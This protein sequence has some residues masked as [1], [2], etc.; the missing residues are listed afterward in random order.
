MMALTLGLVLNVGLTATETDTRKKELIE[1]T[2]GRRVKAVWN[3]GTEKDMKLKFLDTKDGVEI[4]LPFS[5]SAPLITADGFHVLAS[6]G[7]APADRRVKMYDTE[8][9]K[10]T[11]FPAGPGNN[12]LAVW[13][14]PK[15]K[16]TWVY[17]NESGDKGEPWNVPGGGKILRFPVDKPEARELFWDRTSSHIYL[18]FSA[19]GTRACFEPSWSNIGQLKLEFDAEGKVDQ[20]KSTYKTFGGGCFPSMA[21]DNSYRLFRLDGDHRSIS[22]CDADNANV[23]KVVVTGMLTEA[24]KANNTWLTRWSTDPRF[25]TLV[26]PAGA[27]AQIWMGQFDDGYSKIEK[28]VRV[29][30]EKGPQCWQSQVWVEP[31]R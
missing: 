22:M 1:L 6:T 7:K 19:D 16:K 9:K 12:L 2:G 20:A 26:A 4:D 3:Q 30:A 10:V 14:D 24:Q 25:I 21:P 31:K 13:T 28:W 27:N 11:E 17:V 18:M 5:G 23:R 8:T 29:S 15:T